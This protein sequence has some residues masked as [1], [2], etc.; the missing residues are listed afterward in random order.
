M[1]KTEVNVTTVVNND[2]EINFTTTEVNVTTV[3]NNATE[4][5]FTKWPV[6]VKTEVNV[7]IEDK[8]ILI[9]YL[10]KLEKIQSH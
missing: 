3:V 2:T 4:I 5:D 7:N 6:N 10:W 1:Y 9:S 8:Y